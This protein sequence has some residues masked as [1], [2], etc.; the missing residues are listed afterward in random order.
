MHRQRDFL[1]FMILATATATL[2]RTATPA[3]GPAP[4]NPQSATSVPDFSG[5]W[6]KPHLGIESPLSGP[7]P[8]V[9]KF[10]VRQSF[11]IDGRP[12]PAATAPLVG[13]FLQVV[14][15][16]TNPILKP[17]AAEVVKRR[18][19][20]ELSGM[21]FPSA[22]NQCWSEGVPA[23]L[24]AIGIQ[25]LQQPEQITILYEYDNQVRRVRMNQ[26]HPTQVTPSWYGDSV[27]HYEGD[28]LVIDT[29][30][31]KTG[32]LAMVDWFG[33]PFTVALHVVERYR[34]IA[35]EAAREA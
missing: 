17:A 6:A 34:L 22:R 32:P 4:T 26:P 20:M 16:Y 3:E 31:V 35:Y 13:R 7:G 30:G 29:V 28:T 9:N 1:L 8:V 10:R 15:D 2:V 23:I 5:V 33:T 24:A 19:E 14:G 27:G 11:D 21:P 25:M 12:L 18:G